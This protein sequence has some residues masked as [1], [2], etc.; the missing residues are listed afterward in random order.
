V[1]RAF[2]TGASGFIGAAVARRLVAEGVPTAVLMRPSSNPW[3]LGPS[4]P[5]LTVIEGSFHEPA[6][7]E[8]ALADF[9]P[10]TVFHLAWHGVGRARRDDL[11]QVRVNVPGTMDLFAASARA[12]AR[13]FIAAGS[14]AEYG[15]S[16]RRID[17]SHP[18]RPV[19]LYGAAKLATLT[20]LERLAAAHSVRLA[21]L[22]V[23][24][25]YGP[26][27]D[28][29]TLVSMLIRRLLAGERPAVTS[30][31]QLWDYLHVDDSA[32]AFL[33][34][35]RSDAAGVFNVGAGVAPPLRDT[36]ALVRDLIDQSLEIGFGEVPLGRGAVN[37]LEPDVRRLQSAVRW[38]PQITLADGLRATI[39]AER[40]RCGME[41]A[42][43]VL[44]TG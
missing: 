3:R 41:A 17:E 26:Q 7:Y 19:T 15:P 12:G 39:E 42:A 20:V 2:V 23:F 10:D 18:T 27:D 16:D 13:C 28:E 33:A 1:N 32:A 22:R 6:G 4:L 37:T 34:V 25:V 29:N 40:Q 44:V 31:D 9:A 43:N 11:E 5:K 36:M 21:W 14:Q 24:S 38:A 8:A 35:A 30:G